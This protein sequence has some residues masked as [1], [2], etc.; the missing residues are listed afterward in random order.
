MAKIKKICFEQ[1][2]ALE[3]IV[4][5]SPQKDFEEFMKTFDGPAFCQCPLK[6]AY[7]YI[8]ETG[9]PCVVVFKKEG[10]W[11]VLKNGRD[12]MECL[13]LTQARCGS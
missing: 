13:K 6:N 9:K 2:M 3:E 1:D 10:W 4:R 12:F 11:T 7:K 8:Q 5:R